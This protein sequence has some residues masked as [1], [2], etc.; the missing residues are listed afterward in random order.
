MMDFIK[1]RQKR[2]SI[3]LP[4]SAA[5]AYH[6]AS[7]RP[8]GGLNA[9]QLRLLAFLFMLLDHIW[10]ASLLEG[11]FWMTCVGRLAFPIFAFQIAEGFFHT[12][13]RRSYGQRLLLFA[14]LSEVPFDLFYAGIPVYPFA[15]NV[16]FTLFL[17]LLAISAI[18]R[19]RTVRTAKA[20]V[21]GLL[22]T[23]LCWLLSTV[24]FTNYGGM[25]VLTVIAFYLL[26][27]FRGAWAA[28]VIA[29]VLLNAVFFRGQELSLSLLGQT[30]VFQQ[31]GFAVLALLPIWLYNGQ[32]GRSSRALQYGAYAFY[33]VHMLLLYGLYLLMHI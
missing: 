24:L 17:G 7:R 23:A 15:Q 21:L 11:Q 9:N 12:H 19:A 1:Q 29:L 13:D 10:A 26:R 33:P 16:L 3:P 18:D 32:K 28:Q 2:R 8:F 30:V 6:G 31:Q 4:L 22:A 20:V 25:G 5:S 14:L 27:D